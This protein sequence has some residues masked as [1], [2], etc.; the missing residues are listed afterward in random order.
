MNVLRYFRAALAPQFIKRW[1][2]P[3]RDRRR[4]QAFLDHSIISRDLAKEIAIDE[5]FDRLRAM[6]PR[7]WIA[8]YDVERARPF[9][10]TYRQ[11]WSATRAPQP[12]PAVEARDPFVDRRVIEFTTRL[13]GRFLMR[14]GWRKII[15]RD[16]MAG[17]LPDEVRWARGKHHLGA[18]FNACGYETCHRLGAFGHNM[19][20]A[21]LAGYVDAGGAR[22]RLGSLRRPAAIPG[23]CT[24]PI[25][26]P[27][28]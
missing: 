21:R 8:D 4:D 23:R 25:S 9:A 6:F 15:L 26:C 12:G 13:P 20:Q 11:G 17:K 1:V 14:D 5:R 24:R 27:P 2:Q 28:G 22:S 19:L 10:R 3:A 18:L 16:L 7:E